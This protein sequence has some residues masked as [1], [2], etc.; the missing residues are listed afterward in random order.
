[1]NGTPL[2]PGVPA[3]K[4]TRTRTNR[5][6][7]L[8]LAWMVLLA[9]ETLGQV[10][11]KFAG[12]RVGALE[13]NRHSIF[14]ALSTPWLWLGLACYLGQFVIWMRILEKSRLS[15]AFPTSAIA[16]VAIMIASWA[17]FGDPMGWEKILG[18]AIIV[19]GI[20]L[21]GGD[22]HSAPPAPARHDAEGNPP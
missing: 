9:V 20:L 12:T 22:A 21:L 11:L 16:F 2:P 5:L 13:P 14:V 1:M 18:S 10:A 4:E 8:V 19:A 6:S 17:V 7:P 3:A 15:S